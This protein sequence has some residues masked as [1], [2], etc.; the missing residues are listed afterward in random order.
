MNSEFSFDEDFEDEDSNSLRFM[1]WYA[2]LEEIANEYQINVSDRDAWECSFHD[3]MTPKNALEEEYPELFKSSPEKAA[4]SIDALH[5]AEAID[6]PLDQWPG[7]CYGIS[8]A[9]LKANIVKGR[10]V[11]GH[12]RGHVAPGTLFSGRTIIQHGWI[13]T[14]D[15]R[16]VDPTRWVFE[17]AKPYIYEADIGATEDYD[18]GG[19]HYRLKNEKPAPAFNEAERVFKLS[20]EVAPIINGLLQDKQNGMKASLSQ[21][22][23]LANLSLISLGEH[24]KVLYSELDRLNLMAM[25]PLDNKMKIFESNPAN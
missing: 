6:L 25:V 9:V 24:A 16:V 3:G 15:G 2:E 21:M 4:S 17:G 5:V 13:E 7:Q 23:W 11:Y 12:Y 14:E 20:E 22:F 19:N 10:A 18:E 1:N 8:C